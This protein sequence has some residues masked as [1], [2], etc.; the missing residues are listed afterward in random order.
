MQIAL[1]ALTGVIGDADQPGTARLQVL[2]HLFSVGD[3]ADEAAVDDTAGRHDPGDRQL[4]GELSA[5]SALPENFDPTV[6]NRGGSTTSKP[7]QPGAVQMPD[8]ARHDQFAE[9]TTDRLVGPIPEHQFRRDV[10]LQD[11]AELIDGD[12]GVH[13]CIQDCLVE[14]LDQRRGNGVTIVARSHIFRPCTS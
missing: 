2:Q 11:P 1:N 9:I 8:V 12:E 3:V 6:E 10:P 14:R 4:N 13:C 5:V 7:M